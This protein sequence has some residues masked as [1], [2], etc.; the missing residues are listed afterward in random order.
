[1]KA[2]QLIRSIATSAS[3]CLLTAVGAFAEKYA[4]EQYTVPVG[5]RAQGLGG[6]TIA[7]PFDASAGFWNP[8]GINKLSG[9]SLIG[10]HAETFGSLLHHDFVGYVNVSTD[11]SKFLRGW[12]VSAYFLGGDGVFL[13]E[14][15]GNG[16]PQVASEEFHGDVA[17]GISGATEIGAVQLGATLRLLYSDL[18][19]T[20]GYGAA[21]DVG[22][23]YAPHTRLQLG[24]RVRDI[25]SSFI[26]YS[27][28]E[29]QTINPTASPG[30]M[31][32]YSIQDFT[33]RGL[34]SGD[35]RFEGRK[36]GAQYWSGDLSLDTH[37]GLEVEY[38]Q[39]VFLRGGFDVGDLTLGAGVS[40]GALTVD[41]AFLDHDALDDSY[42]FS[43]GW[44]F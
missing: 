43:A 18:V 37:Y 29:T 33:F 44:Q 12:G 38:L 28:F 36:F 14:L 11:T 16:R 23:L 13:T 22:A 21:L 32:T 1:M 24:L 30:L 7:G 34:A 27:D 4:G 26:S 2:Q 5:A 25:T 40:A 20:T 41:F 17:L 31:Y 42:R 9:K 10:M 8:A 15:G 39:R 19:V 35:V 6:A 3:L